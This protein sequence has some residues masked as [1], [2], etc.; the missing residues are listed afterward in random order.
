[1]KTLHTA[2][3]GCGLISKNHLKALKNVEHAECVAV[4][5]IVL[6][7]AETTAE[8]YKIPQVY[9][10]YKEMLKNPDIDVIHICTPHYLHAEM[11]IDTLNAGK[12]VLC[13]KPMALSEADALQMMRARDRSGKQLGICFQNR[14]N[15]AS[16][17]MKKLLEKGGLGPVTGA[18]GR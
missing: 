12:H 9:T 15:Q 18:R 14:Y 11:A 1:M 17:Y 3:I 4:C 2:V 7:K 6:E 10:D 5:D 16:V 13:E 8:S